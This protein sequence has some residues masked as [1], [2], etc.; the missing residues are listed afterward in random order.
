MLIISRGKGLFGGTVCIIIGIILVYNSKSLSQ[1][2]MEFTKEGIIGAFNLNNYFVIRKV[3]EK[4]EIKYDDIE[5]IIVQKIKIR[6]WVAFWLAVC[7]NYLKDYD[8]HTEQT[9][10][11]I[12]L[13]GTII[14]IVL[15]S[16][17][18][19]MRSKYFSRICIKMKDE[20]TIHSTIVHWNQEE[21]FKNVS[22]EFQKWENKDLLDKLTM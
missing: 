22:E 2:Y 9:T 10:F 7:G 17:P 18:I 4:M 19:Y 5:N 12:K 20:N 14:F 1:S 3:S 8:Y 21:V 16:L 6:W 11:L 13:A 15:I